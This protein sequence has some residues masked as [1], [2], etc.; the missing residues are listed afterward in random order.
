MATVKDR[1]WVADASG[2]RIQRPANVP[3]GR[4]IGWI[5]TKLGIVA[6]EQWFW[7]KKPLATIRIEFVHKSF[8]MCRWIQRK[9]PYSR[10]YLVTLARR[11]AEEIVYGKK[12]KG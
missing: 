3:P 12:P 8:H 4:F 11:F 2:W 10:R 7:E 1:V 5:A 6:I 9:Q